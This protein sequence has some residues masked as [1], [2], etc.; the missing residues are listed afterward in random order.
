MATS[1][2]AIYKW[3]I[4]DN[5]CLI[6]FRRSNDGHGNASERGGRALMWEDRVESLVRGK[7]R[8]KDRSWGILVGE[9]GPGYLC[10]AGNEKQ[11]RI[12]ITARATIAGYDSYRLSD[13]TNISI[14]VYTYQC[15]VGL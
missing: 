8:K 5:R 9:T 4:A 3:N 7:F 2:M 14:F 10:H 11:M 13:A 1:E 12:E 15:W 6:P